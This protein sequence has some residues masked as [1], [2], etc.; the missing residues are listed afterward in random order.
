MPTNSRHTI[1]GTIIAVGTL[2]FITIMLIHFPS[3]DG[4]T[5]TVDDDGG[6]DYKTIQEAIDNA[7]AGDT[8]DV[9]AGTYF[10]NIVID[11][12]LTILGNGSVD[13]IIDGTGTGPCVNI[14]AD[15]CKLSGFNITKGTTGIFVGGENVTIS[16][17]AVS[18]NADHGVQAES[19]ANV[20]VD[21]STIDNNGRNG[22]Y[23]KYSN[24]SSVVNCSSI[25]NSGNG[26]FIRDS[27]HNAISYSTASNNT[28]NGAFIDPSKYQVLL[29]VK[30]VDND[31]HG[32][33]GFEI[34]YMATENLEASRNGGSGVSLRKSTDISSWGLVMNYNTESGLD[35]FDC[36][37]LRI[38]NS[39]ASDNG[40]DGYT[41]DSVDKAILEQC[42]ASMNMAG[43]FYLAYCSGITLTEVK[44]NDNS[45]QGIYAFDVIDLALTDSEFKRNWDEGGYFGKLDGFNIYSSIFESNSNNGLTINGSKDGEIKNSS[46]KSNSG[47]GLEMMH[48]RDTLIDSIRSSYNAKD[49]ARLLDQAM[50]DLMNT[51]FGDNDGNGLSITDSDEC[52]VEKTEISG[53]D[54]VGLD[55]FQTTDL[56]IDEIILRNN[57]LREI[58]AM[59]CEGVQFRRS[60]I[61]NSRSEVLI[62][63][64]ASVIKL[65]DSKVS[66]TGQK[67]GADDQ[68]YL[69]S[70]EDSS[71]VTGQN[72]TFSSYP[73]TFDF[74]LGHGV[75]L[76]G[77]ENPPS[78]PDGKADI[79]RYL[80]ATG[81]T[82]DSWLNITFHYNESNLEN[83]DELSLL[84]H[85]HNGSAWSPYAGSQ[86]DE[87]ANTI[88]ANLTEFGIIAPLGTSTQEDPTPVHNINTGENF[89]TIQEAIDDP[90]T[91]DGHTI[92][93]DEGTYTER[94]TVSK[95]LELRPSDGSGNSDVTIDA[96]GGYG[97]RIQANGTT[98]RNITI[99]NGS[100]GV[101]VYHEHFEVWGVN[102]TGCEIH[103]FTDVGIQFTMVRGCTI[104][105]SSIH[106]IDNSGIFMNQTFDSQILDSSFFIAD[107][108]IYIA[109]PCTNITISGCEVFNTN[110]GIRLSQTAQNTITGC[111]IREQHFNGI[112]L[113]WTSDN[114]ITGNWIFANDRGIAISNSNSNL[115]YDNLFNNT[116]NVG[117]HSEENWWNISKTPGT[118]IIGGTYL[119]GNAWYDYEG[120]DID[121]DGLGDTRLVYNASGN[122]ESGG[123]ALP[124]VP[125]TVLPVGNLDTGMY[126]ASVQDAIDDPGTLDGHTI[127]VESGSYVW[128]TGVTKE[129]T[130]RSQTGDPADCTIASDETHESVFSI[131]SSNVTISGFTLTDATEFSAGG[132]RIDG[133]QYCVIEN[134]ILIGN[135]HGIMLRDN[136][137]QNV[138]R[139]NLATGNDD[140]GIYLHSSRSN[141]IEDNN[142]SANEFDG[143]LLIESK[144]NHIQR[145]ILMSNMDSGMKFYSSD[146]N[147]VRF[148]QIESNGAS[149]NPAQFSNGI[150]LMESHENTFHNNSVSGNANSAFYSERDSKRN[151]VTGLALHSY[152]TLISFTFG[153]GIAIDSVDV[154]PSPPAAHPDIGKFVN[155]TNVSHES[156]IQL[157]IHY[158]DG[159]ILGFPESTLALWR[160]NGTWSEV[161]DSILDAENN[162]L[163]A[164]ITSFS[165]ISPLGTPGEN[166]PPTISITSPTNG[167]EVSGTITFTG[168][169]TDPEGV[170]TVQAIQ[171]SL[172]GVTWDII[173]T[174]ASWSHSLDTTT[175]DNGN[176]T[177]FFRAYDGKNFSEPAEL[178]I[179]V[180]NVDPVNTPPEVTITG[181]ANNTLAIGTIT[182]AGTATDAE[183]GETIEEVELRID[184]GT[185]VKVAG[186]TAWQFELSTT[187]LTN[188][189]HVVSV[190]ASD[191][192][193][194]SDIVQI[195]I[196]VQNP[197]SPNISPTVTIISP[198][199]GSTV[200]GLITVEG[201]ADD[202]D[203]TVTQVEI[204]IG[205]GDWTIVTGITSW[206]FELNVSSLKP[207]PLTVK[208]RAF[209][210]TDYSDDIIWKLTVEKLPDEDDPEEGEDEKEGFI[211]A[212]GPVGVITAFGLM[213]IV[214]TRGR[215]LIRSR[216]RRKR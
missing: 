186:V 207:G 48:D 20:T 66:G 206:S 97:I 24:Y 52:K 160:F 182:I 47:H 33:K 49:G 188:G 56:V 131:T 170:G 5:I 65:Q 36:E 132:I 177:F 172:N 105:D 43:G 151:H 205:E 77:V 195:T 169:T 127:E 32:L 215:T 200:K 40:Y 86:L 92:E 88:S 18:G 106:N 85:T 179:T 68:T 103:N 198:A 46:M 19:N 164:N 167:T 37:N 192:Q 23:L 12:R 210:G 34:G 45:W 161:P 58:N 21:N 8:I 6:E 128:V 136:A 190:R 9:K 61:S 35:A 73:T 175:Y 155:I 139:N 187:T 137:N 90:G 102:I 126:F 101:L 194:F 62:F 108:G 74:S 27:N 14:T 166:T 153:K 176:H 79:D 78:N 147:D 117:D 138:L 70:D 2:F 54:G 4:D 165:V 129:L 133:G 83:V 93:I 28:Q 163:S 121:G 197:I 72:V 216:M 213:C 171:F 64:E 10:E 135:Y 140:S 191:P 125:A 124:L 71:N 113:S 134:N 41:M 55:A 204:A 44:G 96:Y 118:N 63:V 122:I 162:L 42:E 1:T 144:T 199:N 59:K 115:V 107:R 112:Y 203:G 145:N 185:W 100:L 149:G 116:E 119:G 29:E 141:I 193:E 95:S 13:T 89:T 214:S 189:N 84:I 209:D 94:L 57:L 212:F 11:K 202:E 7:T 174:T 152:P 157:T 39:M 208:V 104:K 154:A 69:H 123:D 201:S 180:N 31:G 26:I 130:I 148:N 142:A 15:Q 81:L 150:Y 53:N 109:Y 82:Q 143:I 22:I 38:V 183:G 51:Y 98:L 181:P 30:F 110:H 168:E 16:F 75:N 87:D 196:N 146:R 173:D 76:S 159:D 60:E 25:S 17:C 156:W 50:G 158:S 91:M 67:R 178:T 3:V 120:Q 114:V 184:D 111:T 211:S 99:M 80:E